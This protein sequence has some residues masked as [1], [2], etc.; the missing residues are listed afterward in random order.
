MRDLKNLAFILHIVRKAEEKINRI[1]HTFIQ[2]LIYLLEYGKKVP[3]DYTY[4]MHLYG[5][6]S[7]DLWS[8]LTILQYLEF[9][10]I[11]PDPQGYGY[12]IN[13]TIKSRNFIKRNEALVKDYSKDIDFLIQLLGDQ[14]VE[15]L[16]LLSTT[17]FVN[18]LLSK[19]KN[20]NAKEEII[21]KVNALKPHFSSE[22]IEDALKILEQN[23]LIN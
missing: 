8:D 18:Y 23:N 21:K 12:F 9:L 6:Y 15:T 20:I 1:G 3:L 14:P 17:H 19:Y 22:Q 16:E 13:T 4:K 2:K 7:E 10:D 11:Y 5:P